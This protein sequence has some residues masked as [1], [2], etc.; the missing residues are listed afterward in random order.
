MHRQH[1]RSDVLVTFHEPMVF[2]PK[3]NP[4]L[5]APVDFNITRSITAQM[6]QQISHGTLDSPSWDLI[7]TSK[8]AARIYAP[9]GTRMSLG[10][11]VRVVRTFLD[12]FKTANTAADEQKLDLEN[13][14]KLRDDL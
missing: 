10:D 1:F 11:H 13:V 8:L 5:L 12:A 14:K 6:H 4:E 7:R 2:T 3:D 9:L